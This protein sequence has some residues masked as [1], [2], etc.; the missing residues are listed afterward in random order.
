[1][2]DVVVTDLNRVR[3][4][5]LDLLGA[6]KALRELANKSVKPLTRLLPCRIVTDQQ[7][8]KQSPAW[9]DIARHRGP[10]AAK[11]CSA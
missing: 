4:G 10:L 2:P 1:M 5:F 6:S 7:R 11:V 3:S 9:L 8:P